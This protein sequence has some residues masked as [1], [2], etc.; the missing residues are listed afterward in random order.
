MDNKKLPHKK[1]HKFYCIKCDYSTS[2]TSS[3]KKHLMTEKHNCNLDNIL[4]NKKGAKQYTCEYCNKS[5]KFRSG[6]SKHK[7]KCKDIMF[8]EIKLQEVFDDDGIDDI[9]L[10]DKNEL[11]SLLL[12]LRKHTNNINKKLEEAVKQPQTV[13]N[14][15]NNNNKMT[16][17]V[18]LNEQCKDAMNL[19]DFVNKI[20]VSLKDL[21][22]SK[23]N[24]FIDGVTNIF[25]K[26]LQGLKPNERPIHCTD[27]KRL[28]FY[29]KDDDK[30]EKDM[31][32]TKIDST[33]TNIKLKQ[34]E[35][36]SEWEKL[37]PTYRD[38]PILLDVWQ[39]MIAGIT[40]NTYGNVLKEKMALKRRIASYIE[41]KDAMGIQ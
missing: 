14:N 7:K 34:C 39:N 10:N 17:N 25:T 11:K 9:K 13:Y 2:R 36:I 3:W 16:I 8:E 19:T 35:K 29:I 38:D 4:D 24:G 12:E 31:D 28:Q 40:E 23:D 5:Y 32:N 15:V 6:L 26:Q 21:N 18:F 20:T 33:I 22:Y 41:L 27:S 30:W 37:N 1:Q